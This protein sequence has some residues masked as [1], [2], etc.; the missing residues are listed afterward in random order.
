MIVSFMQLQPPAETRRLARAQRL[1]RRF[2]PFAGYGAMITL[3]LVS[4]FEAYRTQGSLSERNVEIYRQYVQEDESLLRARR[5]IWRGSVSVRDFFLSDKPDRVQTLKAEMEEFRNESL[6]AIQELTVP[7]ES[8]REVKHRVREFWDALEGVAAMTDVKGARAH[9]FIMREIVPRRS[10]ASTALAELSEAGRDAVE[11][12]EREFAANR[13]LASRRLLV[14]LGLSLFVGLLVA[15]FSIWRTEH[16]ERERARH[17]EEVLRAKHEMEQ[18]SMRL[19][20]VQEEERGRLSREL[21]DEIGQ[22]LTALRIEISRS[23]TLAGK[24]STEVAERLGRALQLAEK[25]VHNVRDIS[26]LLRPSAL[27]DL[28][29]V[30]ALHSQ[31]QEFSRR[32]GIQ[33]GFSENAVQ[34]ALPNSVKTCV[35]RVVQEALHNCEKHAGASSIQVKLWQGPTSLDLDVEDDGCGTGLGSDGLPEQRGG[36]GVLGMRER[37]A[38]VGGSFSLDSSRGNGLRLS[39]R[40][41][42]IDG[43]KV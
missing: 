13:K 29:L 27:D 38:M 20:E 6:S 30:P 17:Y 12:S 37:I 14:M 22:T 9:D 34:D 39:V 40:I 43:S 8:G 1:S 32:S 10:A 33:C 3:L 36:C 16:L 42:L 31:V 23:Q 24:T 35:Y 28:G 11:N 41:P 5:S 25:V 21:H 7:E 26:H 19:L 4:A 18:L 15:W 2:I